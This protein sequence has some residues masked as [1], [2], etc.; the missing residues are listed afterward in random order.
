MFTFVWRF[1]PFITVL[2]LGV[3]QSIPGELYETARVDGAG[4]PGRFLY[5]TVPSLQKVGAIALIL[6]SSFIVFDDIYALMG[7]DESTKTPM[8]NNYE[9]TFV[10]GRFGKGSAMAYLIGIFLFILTVAYIRMSLK[11]EKL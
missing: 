4:V 2:F 10:M 6:I 11:E 7:Y 8:I 5:V 3:L 9:I 1:S